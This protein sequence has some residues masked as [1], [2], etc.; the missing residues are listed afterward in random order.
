M[1][2]SFIGFPY[3]KIHLEIVEKV[4]NHVFQSPA[5]HIFFVLILFL[6]TMYYHCHIQ[7]ANV[8]IS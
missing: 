4:N 2:S 7:N 8:P 3:L 1:S 6:T 5:L